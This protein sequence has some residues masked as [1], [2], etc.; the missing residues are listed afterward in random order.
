MVLATLGDFVDEPA[1]S[2]E[3]IILATLPTAFGA[4][5]F[6]QLMAYLHFLRYAASVLLARTRGT[7]RERD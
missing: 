2:K 4:L 5:G 1:L 7:P 6:Q 3:Q